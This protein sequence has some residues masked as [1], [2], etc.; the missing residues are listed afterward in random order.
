MRLA[1]TTLTRCVDDAVVELRHYNVEADGRQISLFKEA[2]LDRL[3]KDDRTLLQAIGTTVIGLSFTLLG[4]AFS[5][6]YQAFEIKSTIAKII[7]IVLAIIIGL[8]CLFGGSYLVV[9]SSR[10]NPK[11][12]P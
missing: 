10:Q 11:H 9:K 6:A 8:L 12:P 2:H 1:V 7:V 3:T 4:F 5:Y